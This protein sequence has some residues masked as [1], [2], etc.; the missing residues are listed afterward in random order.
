MTLLQSWKES[1]SIFS[2]S[3]FFRF[4]ED[5]LRLIGRSYLVMVKK[6]LW[7]FVTYGGIFVL[8]ILLGRYLKRVV[9]MSGSPQLSPFGQGLFSIIFLFNLITTILW[10]L[11]LFVVYLSIKQASEKKE[12]FGLKA[13]IGHFLYLFLPV[14]CFK[15]GLSYY[16]RFIIEDIHMSPYL[17]VLLLYLDLMVLTLLNFM[18]VVFF[19]LYFLDT[20]ATLKNV[21]KSFVL[22]IKL[23]WYNLP[24]FIIFTIFWS[25]VGRLLA[26]VLTTLFIGLATVSINYLVAFLFLFSYL[27]LPLTIGFYAQFYV[28]QKY[29]A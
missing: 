6:Y 8:R 22:G 3:K 18:P 25:L 7:L 26:P 28:M 9:M 14:L 27:L 23:F 17:K 4:L 1:L 2:L 11:L 19:M 15:F 20:P 16:A 29:K 5:S 10:Y 24:F 13:Y 12:R 21:W